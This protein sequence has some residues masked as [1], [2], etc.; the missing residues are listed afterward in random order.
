MPTKITTKIYPDTKNYHVGTKNLSMFQINSGVKF[1]TCPR[2]LMANIDGLNDT[3]M[4]RL[5]IC[6]LLVL[7]KASEGPIFPTTVVLGKSVHAQN[8]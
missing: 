6:V 3:H 4:S 1:K 2:R 7:R 8:T 5:T